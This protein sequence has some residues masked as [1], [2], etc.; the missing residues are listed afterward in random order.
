M[1]FCRLQL[2]GLLL[3]GW[4][5]APAA[6]VIILGP[7]NDPNGGRNLVTAT[8]HA[9]GNLD[10][11]VGT[12]G[13]FLGTP[14]SPTHFVTATHVGSGGTFVY[15]GKTYQ[16]NPI[17]AGSQDDLTVWQLAAGEAPFTHWSPLYLGNLEQGKEL[18]TLG[19]GTQRGAAYEAPAGTPRGWHFGNGDSLVSWGTNQVRGIVN[20]SQFPSLGPPYQGDFLYFT[21]DQRFQGD[22]LAGSFD[23]GMLSG[24][25][26]GGPL[27]ILDSDGVYKLAGINS[28]IDSGIDE[29]G[30]G[31]GA[32]FDVLGL[33][34]GGQTIV[35]DPPSDL[36]PIPLGA[37]ATR[38]STHDT[39]LL[40]FAVAPVP[41]PSTL[42]LTIAAGVF[43]WR[44]YVS[45][46]PRS[47]S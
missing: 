5:P 9:P 40:Q 3:T 26:S 27:F 1:K 15:D 4:I 2:L 11:Y 21:F 32:L 25:D 35:N 47:T 12:W 33:H 7:G 38:I 10:A 46:R 44:R 28:L 30:G 29:L 13:G 41:E 20:S 31:S 18:V 45:N 34:A 36:T 22:N 17:A 42:L 16:V 14:I 37:Y 23:E 6:A 8:S 24:G 19:R 39:F 43:G